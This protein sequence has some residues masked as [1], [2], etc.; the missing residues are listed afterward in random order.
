[1]VK[2]T[3]FEVRGLG[4]TGCGTSAKSFHFSALHLWRG[5]TCL[6]E[7]GQILKHKFPNTMSDKTTL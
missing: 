5:Y 2:N 7:V 6:Q 1:M 3:D 4:F